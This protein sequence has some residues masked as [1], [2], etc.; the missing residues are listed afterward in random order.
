MKI[1][2]FNLSA[3]FLIFCLLHSTAQANKLDDYIIGKDDR[4][5]I[6]THSYP[7]SSIGKLVIKNN[8][9]L[10]VCSG[11]LIGKNL[12]LTAAHCLITRKNQKV[13]PSQIY[14]F[15]KFQND[16]P[17]YKSNVL[18]YYHPHHFHNFPTSP[19]LYN[20]VNDWA[21]LVLKK[22]L[23]T[24]VG[25]FNVDQARYP[26]NQTKIRINHSGYE[27]ENTTLQNHLGCYIYKQKIS[28]KFFYHD[29]D[30]LPGASGGP[31]W[32]YKNG[33]PTVLAVDT[34]NEVKLSTTGRKRVRGVSSAG[35]YSTYLQLK[36][37]GY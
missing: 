3:L 30:S 14:F 36:A 18:T 29:C 16:K 34:G 25:F 20:Y 13:S 9:T 6:M 26:K 11:T 4:V 5:P 27:L 37:K 2:I 23:G 33:Q 12:V 7:W 32:L 1:R 28:S 35:F 31:I 15:T 10:S 21:I 8:K 24:Q 19:S 17:I 22:P